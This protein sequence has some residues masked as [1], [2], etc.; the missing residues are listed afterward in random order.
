MLVHQGHFMVKCF[1]FKNPVYNLKLILS[2][3]TFL[4]VVISFLSI[5]LFSCIHSIFFTYFFLNLILPLAQLLSFMSL[6]PSEEGCVVPV[7]QEDAYIN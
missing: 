1:K 6:I 4:C 5:R 3:V 2:S 7:V